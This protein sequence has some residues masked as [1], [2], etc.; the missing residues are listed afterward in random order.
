MADDRLVRFAQDCSHAYGEAV[1]AFEI[2]E[3]TAERYAERP[4][5]DGPFLRPGGSG[6][7]A[8]G[9]HHVDVRPA[10]DGGFMAAVDGWT[11]RS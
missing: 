10:P 3:L 6:W 1:R 11:S 8:G 2:T 5:Q 9:M 4:L 7:N